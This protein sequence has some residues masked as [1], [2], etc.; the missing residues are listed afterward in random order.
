[1]SDSTKKLILSDQTGDSRKKLTA[2]REAWL[3]HNPNELT[4]V[5]LYSIL[6]TAPISN[7]LR[8]LINEEYKYLKANDLI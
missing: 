7:T 2:I 3:K 8:L 4:D 5:E 1:M 6:Q